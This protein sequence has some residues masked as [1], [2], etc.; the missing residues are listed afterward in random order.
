MCVQFKD[1]KVRKKYWVITEDWIPEDKFAT[2]KVIKYVTLLEIKPEH[3]YS[4]DVILFDLHFEEEVTSSVQVNYKSGSNPAYSVFNIWEEAFEDVSKDCVATIADSK[5][6]I[7]ALQTSIK[8]CKRELETI[9]K[10]HEEK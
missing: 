1:L 6:K 10:A 9:R 7:R 5:A 8:S 4:V 3:Q 2:R